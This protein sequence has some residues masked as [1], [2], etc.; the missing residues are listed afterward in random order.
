MCNKNRSVQNIQADMQENKEI[1]AF[2]LVLTQVL[3]GYSRTYNEPCLL[4]TNNA[5]SQN[6]KIP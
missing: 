5:N 4:G 2:Q 6:F 1:R 3:N